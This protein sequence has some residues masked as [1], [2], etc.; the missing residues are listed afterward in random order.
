[1]GDTVLSRQEYYISE[2]LLT[3]LFSGR[4]KH[5]P[6]R[7]LELLYSD[8]FKG[9]K[10]REVVPLPLRPVDVTQKLDL[11]QIFAELPPTRQVEVLALSALIERERK[12]L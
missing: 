3:R 4:Q 10:L 12:R 1:M 2:G 7:L 6:A 11:D 5:V 8:L 9:S